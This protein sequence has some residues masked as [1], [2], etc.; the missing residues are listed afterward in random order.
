MGTNKEQM[1]KSDSQ[2]NYESAVLDFLDKEMAAV[3]P[4]KQQDEPGQEVD[5]LVTDLLKQVITESDQ[6]NGAPSGGSE[7]V[8]DNMESL[9]SEFPP[10]EVKETPSSSKNLEPPDKEAISPPADAKHHKPAESAQEP[11]VRVPL[12]PRTP[13]FAL[14]MAPRRK[15]P[16]IAVASTCLLIIIGTAVYYLW[17]A[18]KS[19]ADTLEFQP[20]AATSLAPENTNMV[21][22]VDPQMPTAAELE[23]PSPTLKSEAPKQILPKPDKK[24]PAAPSSSS[25][26]ASPVQVAASPEPEPSAPVVTNSILAI[27]PTS[28]IVKPLTTQTSA[29]SPLMVASNLS[30]DKS[31]LPPMPEGIT[32]ANSALERNPASSG[33]RNLAPSIL[34]SQVSPV[35]PE[36]AIRS[37]TSGSVVLELQIDKEGKVVK[38][39][40]AS[41]PSVFYGEAVKAAMQYR[42][43][44]ATIDGT[45]V[46]SKS[47][48]TMVF[49]LKR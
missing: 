22:P 4:N 26:P 27:E 3:Q 42:Y 20:A 25:V 36:L 13:K 19:A 1:T 9:L 44:P 17:G 48:V 5:A 34:I 23:A 33:S 32:L 28:V 24:S 43:R 16:M 15:T 2:A 46:S 21:A 18:P 14:G 38:A 6:P 11:P 7:A 39:T 12:S 10:A 45:N 35:Y 30:I 31:A 49:N 40:A 41:G 47:R 37:R 8:S 29:P